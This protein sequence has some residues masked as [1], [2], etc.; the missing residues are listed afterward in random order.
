MYD[1][2]VLKNYQPLIEEY[3]DL[4]RE[5]EEISD[6]E[7][8]TDS[9]WSWFVIMGVIGLTVFHVIRKGYVNK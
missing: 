4:V 9:F 7:A 8:K 2:N 5:D 6:Y 1:E 3:A